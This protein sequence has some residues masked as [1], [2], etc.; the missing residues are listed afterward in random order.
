VSELL[1]NKRLPCREDSPHL[2]AGSFNPRIL[3]PWNIT[4]EVGDVLF[5]MII[6]A[7]KGW[8]KGK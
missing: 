6:M 5:L 1:K 8:S 2:D 4:N 3:G 7:N